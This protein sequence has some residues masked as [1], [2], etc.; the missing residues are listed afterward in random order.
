MK[1]ARRLALP[2]FL[3]L[4]PTFTLTLTLTVTLAAARVFSEEAAPATDPAAVREIEGAIAKLPQ[5]PEALR[6]SRVEAGTTDGRSGVYRGLHPDEI[7]LSNGL[8]RRSFRLLPNAATVAFD[9]LMTGESILRGVKPE[10]TLTLDG[11]EHSIGGLVGQPDYAYLRREWLDA[12]TVDPGSFRCVGFE[13]GMTEARYAWKRKRHASDL[14]WPPPGAS[15]TLCFRAAD[16]ELAGLEVS[17]RY[18]IYDGIPVISKWIEARNATGRSLRLDSF[19]SE[20]LAVVEAESSVEDTGSW[21]RPGLHVETDY[22]FHGSEP[23]GAQAAVR[24]IPDPQYTTQVNYRLETPCLLECRPPLGPEIALA[25]GETFESF[26]AF[27]LAHSSTER[28]ERGLELRR[29]YRT[30]AP[31]V[32]ENPIL[33]HVRSAAPAAVRLA[34]EQCADVGFEMVIMTFGSGFDVENEDPAYRAGIRELVEFAHSKGVEL[35]GYSLLASRRVSD[36]D[37][38]IDPRTGKPGGAIFGNSP[39][40]GSR[41]GLDYFRK[42]RSFIEETGLDVL[43]H[44]GSYPGDVC[45]S[46][47]HPGHSGLGD[48]QWRQWRTISEFYRSCRGRGVYLNVP[49]WYFLQGSTKTAMG[50]REVNWSLSRDRQIIL[51]R[52]NIFDGTWYKTPSMGWMFVPLVEYQGGGA[53]ATLEPLREHL[54]AYG[55]HLAQNFGAGVQACYRGPRLYDSEETRAI[56]KKWT[57]FYR[58]HRP[59]LEADVIHLRRPDGRDWDGILHVDPRLSPCALAMLHNPLDE[60]IRRTVVLPLRHAGLRNAARVREKDGEPRTCA[61]DHEYRVRVPVEIPARGLTWLVIEPG[62]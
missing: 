36:E 26:R 35:G 9:N 20:V 29:L 13:R 2:S 44:D 53:A 59:I 25:P 4:A 33:M 15:L 22:A 32:T 52:Q 39:C 17:V 12:M 55:Q 58:S 18:E 21:E 47:G 30:V 3:L 14:P 49:D 16:P 19:R 48:S 38:V 45:A 40:L 57:D 7:A 43:E 50:Y 1:I 27:E 5:L 61:L 46:K 62:R 10:A 11:K 54:D 42:V 23:R 60:A 34:V 37:D 41:W 24:W 8:V 56:V 51:G 6:P 31:W 28:E